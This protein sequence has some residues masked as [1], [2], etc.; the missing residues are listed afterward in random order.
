[1]RDPH[2]LLREV[3]QLIVTDLR[4]RQSPNDFCLPSG[5]DRAV[6][7]KGGHDLLVP[8]ILAPCFELLGRP[9]GALAKD[10]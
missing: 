6:A 9:A 2:E 4:E 1:L 7:G 5:W 8:E 3:D 10:R